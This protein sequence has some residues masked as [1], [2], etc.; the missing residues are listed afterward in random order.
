VPGELAASVV[1]CLEGLFEKHG[2]PL[3]MKADNGSAFIA[4]LVAELCRRYGITLLHSP[5]RRPRY[6]G[7]CEVSGRWAKR[8][9]LAAAQERGPPETLCQA[10]LDHA[11]TFTGTMPKIDDALRQSFLAAVARELAG[12]AAERGLVIDD[13]TR[14]HVLRSLTRVAV[15]RALISCHMLTIRGR[16]YPRCLPAHAA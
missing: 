13:H 3:V 2:V 11:V 1:T 12:V 7:T 8:R 9:A 15:Q 5:V 16:E 10:D 4:E 14:D 6:N